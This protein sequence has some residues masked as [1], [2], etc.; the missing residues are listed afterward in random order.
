MC[1]FLLFYLYL[2]TS[3]LRNNI[4][5]VAYLYSSHKFNLFIQ[6][7]WHFSKFLVNN[8]FLYIPS[9]AYKYN[10]TILVQFNISYLFFYNSIMT[11]SFIR[12]LF[13]FKEILN[14]FISHINIISLIIFYVPLEINHIKSWV[15]THTHTPTHTT[16]FKIRQKPPLP[17]AYT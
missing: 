5:L 16:T 10:V 3:C 9:M 15:H 11:P 14:T 1:K 6:N 13:Y 7:V 12:Y 4:T 2:S 17:L 8:S